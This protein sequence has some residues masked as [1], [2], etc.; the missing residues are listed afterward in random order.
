MGILLI[1][2]T[3]IKNKRDARIKK[4]WQPL[5]ACFPKTLHPYPEF[6]NI[7]INSCEILS[8]LV[9]MRWLPSG[10]NWK[11]ITCIYI[12]YFICSYVSRSHKHCVCKKYTWLLTFH[13]NCNTYICTEI[14]C[15]I[16]S[17]AT[18]F[19]TSCVIPMSN[20]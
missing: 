11:H 6:T 19:A 16:I 5:H 10:R 14:K 1:K 18:S 4:F 7:H 17:R 12:V 9:M 2:Q 8:I 13:L 20:T 15:I 3:I